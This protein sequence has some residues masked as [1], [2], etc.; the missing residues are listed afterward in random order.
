MGNLKI[1]LN[2]DVLGWFAELFKFK[3]EYY[4][5]NIPHES[6]FLLRIVHA[7][8]IKMCIHILL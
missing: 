5:N 4:V 2:F 1:L 7:Q 8:D 3:F 6:Q